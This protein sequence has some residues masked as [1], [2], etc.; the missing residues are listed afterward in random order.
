MPRK[1]PES[2]GTAVVLHEQP[3]VNKTLDRQEALDHIGDLVE[4]VTVG[5]RIGR[6]AVAKAGVVRGDDVEAVA[7][8]ADQVP[9]LM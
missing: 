6:V 5:R 8:D 7:Q 3:V 9:I 2:D 4:G 1:Y